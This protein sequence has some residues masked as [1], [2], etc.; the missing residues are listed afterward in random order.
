MAASVAAYEGRSTTARLLGRPLRT[1]SGGRLLQ[2]AYVPGADPGHLRR[3]GGPAGPQLRPGQAAAALAGHGGPRGRDH[4][5]DER[6]PRHADP[7]GGQEPRPGRGL[8]RRAPVR[9]RGLRP[10]DLEHADGGPAGARPAHRRRPRRTTTRGRTRPTPPPTAGCGGPPTPRAAPWGWPRC[11]A[12][13]RPGPEVRPSGGDRRVD[14]TDVADGG[15][16]RR[17]AA[18]RVA[19]GLAEHEVEIG[20][21]RARTEDGRAGSSSSQGCEPAVLAAHDVAVRGLVL[22]TARART[23]PF[24]VTSR[25]SRPW[26]SRVRRPCRGAARPRGRGRG[27][28]GSAMLAMLGLAEVQRLRAGEDQREVARR[29]RGATAG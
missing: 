12:S 29:G 11:S 9:G 16:Q 1:L 23:R 27:C 2:R 28:A 4:R 8:R 25:P 3:A 22:S 21:V 6:R 24:G 19:R 14:G 26:R 13:G 20:A 17:A 10:G 18:D 15:T 7:L 5:V